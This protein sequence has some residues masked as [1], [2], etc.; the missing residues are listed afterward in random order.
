MA[1][2]VYVALQPCLRHVKKAKW[3]LCKDN[4]IFINTG[5]PR[6]IIHFQKLYG[7]LKAAKEVEE[8][9]KPISAHG[10]IASSMPP[11]CL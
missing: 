3:D 5:A 11:C 9:N 6:I 7:H 8:Q 1:K 10:K 2:M 4:R